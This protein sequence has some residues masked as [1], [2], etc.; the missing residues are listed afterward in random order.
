M[1]K[2]KSST[3][4]VNYGNWVP[5]KLIYFFGFLSVIFF[6]LS[7]I[8]LL[9]LIGAV[10]FLVPLIYFTCAYYLFSPKGG[11]LQSKFR[12]LMFSLLVWNG[13]GKLLDIG[14]G[15]GALAI[16]VAKKYPK[17]Q[18]TGIDYWGKSWDY[19]QQSCEKNA[20]IADVANRTTFQK[21]S[22]AKLPFADDSFDVAVSSFVFH[23]V[24]DAKDKKEVI[25]EALRVVKKGGLF[26]FQD[27]FLDKGI[28]GEPQDL[29]AII[30]DWGVQDVNLL[31]TRDQE[32]IPRVLKP[33]F[34]L[35]SVGIIYGKK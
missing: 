3:P 18:V 5:K 27:L 14:C 33:S 4:Q 21:A 35:G 34:M 11:N 2:N 7:Y 13:D 31:H 26:V 25:K 10:L 20:E 12:D 23:E 16:D 28:Y 29:L 24:R 22:A 6:G 19:S 15:N 8:S 30:K 1:R 32:F 9:F 17:A